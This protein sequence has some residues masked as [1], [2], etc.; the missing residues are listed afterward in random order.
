MMA[1][2][3]RVPRRW[4]MARACRDVGAVLLLLVAASVHAEAQS[5]P[6]LRDSLLARLATDQAIRDTLVSGMRDGGE[7]APALLG[8]MLTVDAANTRWLREVL[9]RHGWPGRR[10]VGADGASA[11]FLLVQHADADT[12]FQARVLPLLEEAHRAGEA[13]GDQVALLTD[14]LAVARG[15]PQPYGSQARIENGRVTF[16]PIVDSLHVDARRR[17]MGLPPLAEYRRVL[18]SVYTKAGPPP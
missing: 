10:L 9:A 7:P 6:A 13:D 14:R 17:T 3:C 11:A 16:H 5:L 18:E 4:R 2:A 15:A 1:C 12:A 8:R